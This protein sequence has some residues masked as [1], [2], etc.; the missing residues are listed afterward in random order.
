MQLKSLI[1]RLF[2]SPK[3]ATLGV[4]VGSAQSTMSITDELPFKGYTEGNTAIKF[5]DLLSDADLDELNHILKWNCFVVDQ[6]GRRFGGM[7]RKGKRD[8]PQV[9]PDPRI[10]RLHERFD[11]SDKSVLEVGCFEGVHTVGLLQY[12][13]KVIAIDSRIENVVKTMVRAG[14]FGLSPTVF[15]CD[16]E[17]EGEEMN[18]LKADILHHVG[19]LYHLKD[20]VRHLQ[21]L[22]EYIGTGL[23]LD[24]HIAREEEADKSY[25]VD[26]VIYRYKQYKE[27]GHQDVFSGMYDHAKWLRKE[28]IESLLNQAGFAHVEWAEVRDERNGLRALL[29][30]QR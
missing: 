19:V 17:S 14:F 25:E 30:A 23:M 18:F 20:P 21:S 26:G 7:A 16:L 22:G 11:L 2:T 1:R 24:T 28:D 10:I 6:H 27:G 29:F 4:A 15:K 8:V 9:V 3:Q 5:V 12:A 13:K